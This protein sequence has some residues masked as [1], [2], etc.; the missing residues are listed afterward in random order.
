MEGMASE[1]AGDSMDLWYSL[2]RRIRSGYT[3]QMFQTLRKST[4]L[5]VVTVTAGGIWWSGILFPFLFTGEYNRLHLRFG[6]SIVECTILTITQLFAH[7]P[8]G[9]EMVFIINWLICKIVHFTIIYY[10]VKNEKAAT[11]P[12]SF[13]HN[14][15]THKNTTYE[16]SLNRS[17]SYRNDQL[18]DC[19]YRCHRSR[20]L[21]KNLPLPYR[22]A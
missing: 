22:R 11:Q 18:P 14:N 9:L 21:R 20:P 16:S 15:K 7:T 17:S 8:I 3:G 2:L 1:D 6:Q 12:P 10:P 19:W 13:S 4:Y 5:D